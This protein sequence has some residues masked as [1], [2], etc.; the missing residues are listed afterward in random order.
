[1][2]GPI[3]DAQPLKSTSSGILYGERYPDRK[4]GD[5]PTL[6]LGEVHAT[7]PAP[8][9]FF[10]KFLRAKM[11]KNYSFQIGRLGRERSI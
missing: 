2:R 11:R 5:P 10:G 7:W 4:A 6:F 9:K 3:L 1:M 8:P